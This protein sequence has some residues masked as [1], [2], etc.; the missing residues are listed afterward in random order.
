M[1][2]R[3]IFNLLVFLVFISLVS[4]ESSKSAEKEKTGGIEKM[5]VIGTRAAPRSMGDST[6]PLDII[7]A[8]ELK[9]QGST[10]MLSMIQAMV[11]SFNVNEQQIN[12]AS[13]FV[14][15]ANLRGLSSDHTLVLVN[16]KRRHRSAVITFLGGGLSDGSQGPDISTIPAIALKQ[17]EVL[18]DGA[19]AQYGS[20]AIA[21]AIN[22]VLKDSNQGGT[23]EVQYGGYYEGDGN[24]A[25]YSGNVGVPL[26][27]KGFANFS[28]ESRNVSETSRSIQRGGAAAL[29][30]AGNTFVKNPAQTWG[31]PEVNQ[32][33]KF[34]VNSGFDISSRMHVY[35]FG[36]YAQRAVDGGFYFRN[37][38]TRSGVYRGENGTDLLV[39]DMD[40]VGNGIPCPTVPLGDNVLDDPS[41]EIIADNTT[42]VGKNCW[43]FNER[44]PGGFTPRFAGTIKDTS[45]TTGLKGKTS[46]DWS[47]DLSTSWGKNHISYSIYNTVN[48]SLGAS[49]PTSFKPGDYI[50]DEKSI[51]LSVEKT[52]DIGLREPVS[53]AG[54]AEYRYESFESIAGD[55]ASYEAGPLADQGFGVGSNGFPGLNKKYEEKEGRNSTALYLDVETYPLEDTV[56]GVAIR[57]E[58]FSDFGSTTNGKLA[59]R[60]QLNGSWAVRGALSTGFKA[61]TIGQSNVRNVTTAFTEDGL[62]DRATLP[63]SDPISQ[64]KGANPLKPENSVNFSFG[65]VGELDNGFFLTLDYFRIDIED[66]IS[67]TSGI[68]LTQEDIDDLTSRGVEDASSFSEVSFFT[69]DFKT[70]TQGIDLV[71]NYDVNMF[72]GQTR[73]A[74]ALNWTDT[75]VKDVKL[76]SRDDGEPEANLSDARIKNIEGNLP[77]VRH[78]LTTTH[79]NGDWRFLGRVNYFSS[80]FEDHLDSNLPLED[81][82]AEYT[83]DLEVGYDFN[84]NLNFVVGAKNVLDERPDENKLYGKMAGARYALTSPIGTGGGFYY[85]RGAYRF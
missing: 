72:R 78:S 56:V 16:G 64:K 65:F 47:Y 48:P 82:S 32:D 15:P 3:N 58:N 57:H 42:D 84:N 19:S 39:G 22:F 36:N 59:T 61:P 80:I 25:Q 81:I 41:Y 77:S 52:L 50:Q 26:T 40:G 29:I 69:N 34:F 62:R 2:V 45:L 27:K 74:F 35:L 8:E 46:G 76:F 79:L 31:S 70:I 23:L 60:Y 43:A 75:E 66:R 63:P 13:T 17:L 68:T 53:M 24:G 20:D 37:P 71:A 9:Q 4:A 5:A 28:F 10:D 85:V 18:R 83:L 38:H 7:S 14:R 1:E 73:F 54:G 6:V 21:G 51:E 30:E 12:D 44:F 11:P 33:L 49:S 55:R 67:T